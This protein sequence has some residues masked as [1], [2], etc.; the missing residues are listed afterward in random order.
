MWISTLFYLC[1]LLSPTRC[2]QML[3]I[4]LSCCDVFPRSH[5]TETRLYKKRFYSQFVPFIQYRGKARKCPVAV[6]DL[7]KLGDLSSRRRRERD[8]EDFNV[9][10]RTLSLVS[11]CIFIKIFYLFYVVVTL[12]RH[13]YSLWSLSF[14]PPLSL[15][16]T[17]SNI[18]ND[19]LEFFS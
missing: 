1:L 15:W 14:L 13:F 7:W 8:T 10:F 2:H 16:R 5:W 11:F 17:S 3:L 4:Y 19:I 12:R 18:G 9:I 6:V